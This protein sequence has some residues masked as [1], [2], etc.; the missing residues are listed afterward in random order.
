MFVFLLAESVL[1]VFHPCCRWMWCVCVR[2]LT[3]LC[4]ILFYFL[5]LRKRS[6]FCAQYTNTIVT[7]QHITN[8]KD[9]LFVVHKPRT[10]ENTVAI[11]LFIV[12]THKM[13][14]YL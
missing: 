10:H 6:L 13:S 2:V 9:H 14:R 12:G 11:I 7:P 5:V 1:I 3:N 8:I 4:I